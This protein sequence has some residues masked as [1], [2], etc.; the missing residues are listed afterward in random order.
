M[1]YTT[2]QKKTSSP[3]VSYLDQA[4]NECVQIM[5]QEIGSRP[6][7]TWFDSVIFT[8]WDAVSRLAH[9]QAPNNFVKEWILKEYMQQC[10]K[11]L[12]RVLNVK[13]IEIKIGISSQEKLSNP[14]A[15]AHI[16]A[17][18]HQQA[19]R[20]ASL[21]A[22]EKNFQ[23]NI[24]EKKDAH[25]IRKIAAGK[26]IPGTHINSAYTFDSFIV[27]PSNDLA[28]AAS[29]AVAQKTNMMYN[30]LFIYGKSGLGKTHL[31]NAIG[32]H[33][34]QSHNN[35]KVLYQPIEKFIQQ[36]IHAI[37]CNTVDRFEQS[38]SNI[39]ILLLDDIQYICKKEQ[40]QEIF[41]KIF[42]TLQQKKHQIVVT[43]NCIPRE[44]KGLTDRLRSR[45]E[46]GL[47]V[48]MNMPPFET[49]I[50]IIHKKAVLYGMNLNQ[51]VA[52]YIVSNVSS[53]IRELEGVLIR[54]SAYVSLTKRPLCVATA[55]HVLSFQEQKT[56][57]VIDLKEIISCISTRYRISLTVLRSDV[58]EKKIVQI[59]HIALY[60]MRHLTQKSFQDIGEYL[61]K[62]HTSVMHAYQKISAARIEKKELDLEIREL[63]R[64]I[65]GTLD[66]KS[67][68]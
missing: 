50:D 1:A 26:L 25:N 38:F 34:L 56:R 19:I 64:L 58:R 45:F 44:M 37:R 48:D 18:L 49:L 17:L 65:Q 59:R 42:T 66:T 16:D 57:A 30:P 54:L 62:D 12:S 4:W 68:L 21:A 52:Q 8:Q 23:S 51:E 35:A 9:L 22:N 55:S 11:C 31:L 67:I 3:V 39:D 61:H 24:I 28:F 40:T 6:V 60:L 53:S 7:D 15:Q 5:K 36:F 33:I 13:T 2:Y 46:G 63:E 29:K 27:G 14:Q 41:F 47:I 20:P 32:N 10:Q 43:S